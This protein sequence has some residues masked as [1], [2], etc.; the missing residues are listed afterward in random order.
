MPAGD[1]RPEWGAMLRDKGGIGPHDPRDPGRHLD[2]KVSRLVYELRDAGVTTQVAAMQAIAAREGAGLMPGQIAAALWQ[3]AP[4]AELTTPDD[5]L[6]DE[7]DDDPP[8]VAWALRPVGPA[9][10]PPGQ[11]HPEDD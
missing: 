10:E 8:G 9:Y 6:H 11:R 2:P 1:A 5:E 3:F 7:G 4:P